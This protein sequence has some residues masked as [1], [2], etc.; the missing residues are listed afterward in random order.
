MI[1]GITQSTLGAVTMR[2][3]KKFMRPL[4]DGVKPVP[5]LLRNEGYQTG[6]IKKGQFHTNG[7][8]DW[9]FIFDQ[10][11]WD[12]KQLDSVDTSKPFY[13]QFNI[14]QAHRPYVQ[15]KKHPV[16][17]KT[18]DLPPY[19][20]DHPVMRKSWSDYLESIQDLDKSVGKILAWL[21]ESNLSENTIVFFLSDHGE[22]FL[23]GKYF[24]YDC[25]LNQPLI[26]RWPKSCHP[27]AGYESGATS[28]KMLASIDIAAQ[29][30][31]C[32]GVEQP[33]W[34]HGQ[35]FLSTKE[36]SRN[37]IY[38]AADWYGGAKLKSRSIR[39]EE[40]KYIR[41]FKTDISPQ[42]VSSEYR[43]ALHPLYHLTEIL[44]ERGELEPIHR[45]LL[46]NNLEEEELYDLQADPHEMN[47]LIGNQEFTEV[48]QQLK[49][50]LTDLI[51]ETGDLG[52]EPLDPEHAEYFD[53]Y[54]IIQEK[55]NRKRREALREKVLKAVEAG[56]E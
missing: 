32:A 11:S 34:M 2:P 31:Q 12:T 38:S 26:I 55:N 51:K 47:N 28:D 9:N 21:D 41:N 13:L 52:F 49:Q 17:P 37:E 7:K 25:S 36:K 24:L 20:P 8:D 3:P 30:L 44:E 48:H 46:L 33:S 23:R 19:Y 5:A 1:T 50:R 56:G 27:P 40:F 42:S 6:N 16:N 14:F 4:P 22:A 43:R 29:T 54:R 53:N 39:T 10:K 35:E 15:D 18:V 45:K